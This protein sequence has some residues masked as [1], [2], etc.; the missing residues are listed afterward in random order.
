MFEF[1]LA[2]FPGQ[3]LVPHISDTLLKSVLF[4]SAVENTVHKQHYRLACFSV[5]IK[6]IRKI[7]TVNS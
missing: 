6:K 7:T 1:S 3:K 5:G 4:D 2:S